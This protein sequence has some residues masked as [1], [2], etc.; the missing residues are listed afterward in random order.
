ME[1]KR[2]LLAYRILSFLEKTNFKNHNIL[3]DNETIRCINYKVLEEADITSEGDS[4]TIKLKASNERVF[5]WTCRSD[6]KTLYYFHDDD[7]KVS[8]MFCRFYGI[9]YEND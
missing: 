4:V 9:D 5:K 2:K 6:T 1:L 8:E 3:I 7:R